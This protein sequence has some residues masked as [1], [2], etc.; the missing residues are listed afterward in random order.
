MT[1]LLQKA[2]APA[3]FRLEASS[4]FGTLQP[5]KGEQ[6]LRFNRSSPSKKA[7]PRKEPMRCVMEN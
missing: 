4:T 5:I 3:Q 1:L 7:A 2:L 6:Q